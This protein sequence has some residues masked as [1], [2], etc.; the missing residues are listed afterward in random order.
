[1]EQGFSQR[2]S[3][4]VADIARSVYEYVCDEE[5]DRKLVRKIGGIAR[6]HQRYGYRRV[7]ALL[8]RAEKKGVYRLWKK[9][10]LAVSRRRS[11]KRARKGGPVPRKA[12]YPGHVW[13][14][15]FMQDQTADGRSLK[16]LTVVDE[17]TRESIAI[18]VER[19]RPA[20]VVIEV[21]REA[22]RGYGAPE[23]LRSDNSPEFIAEAVQTWL[24]GQGTKTPY[25]DPA[26]PWQNAF[27]ESFNDKLRQECLNLEVLETL[28][29]AK[30]VIGRWR[31]AYNGERP[32][33]SLGYRTPK[34]F[35]AAWEK[36]FSSSR[37][38]GSLGS[39]GVRAREE[40]KLWVSRGAEPR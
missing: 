32:H 40:E 9:L 4:A 8:R 12:L 10:G 24:A 19:R 37:A 33:S 27:G 25:I 1:M 21:L 14:Y 29:E 2:Q 5:E 18:R 31:R 35:R 36:E 38:P 39:L 15:D 23:F 7:W 16:I 34:E 13:T 30:V 6:K 26:S 17:F 20:A 11:R 3:C 22:F 28:E